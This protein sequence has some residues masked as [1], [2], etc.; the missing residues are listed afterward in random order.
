MG[1]RSVVWPNVNRDET[2]R[3][4]S[5]IQM[6]PESEPFGPISIAS[7]LPSGERSV[8]RIS[9]GSASCCSS[10]PWTSV[11]TTAAG[12]TAAE[13]QN[14]SPRGRE[15]SESDVIDAEFSAS[16]VGS[17]ALPANV[18]KRANVRMVQTRD[19]ARLALEPLA[20]ISIV[21]KMLRKHFDSDDTVEACVFSLVDFARPA[22]MAA[23]IS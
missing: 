1:V 11:Q 12:F 23:R 20:Q 15:V 14:T 19:R 9:P 6:S 16:G 18:M 22:P 21:G 10:S 8:A 5:R 4:K 3:T 2:P 7:H 13:G 17:P